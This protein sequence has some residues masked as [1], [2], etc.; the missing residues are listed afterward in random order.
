[1]ALFGKSKKGGTL[2]VDIGASS[3]KLV[4]LANE[5]FDNYNFH[6]PAIQIKHFIWETF[7]SHYME[8]VKNRAYNQEGR[9]SP[10]EQQGA[11]TTLYH[12]LETILQLL[13][14]IMPM[15]CYKLSMDIFEKDVHFEE[16]PKVG[17]RHKTA[18][19]T[20]QLLELDSAIWK[21]KRDKAVSLKAEVQKAVLPEVF[22]A[23]EKDLT[24]TH[25][26]KQVE[27]GKELSVEL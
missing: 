22:K 19:T 4:E 8:L 23:I 11:I 18:F 15:L 21:A 26:I 27:Y 2:G 17:E 9:Y 10:E 20:E 24:S 6:E 5:S 14:P 7:A 1:M 12:C 13:A 25:G 3:I 16:F